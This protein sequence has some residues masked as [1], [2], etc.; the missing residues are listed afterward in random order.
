MTQKKP[1]NSESL[2]EKEEQ[3]N[4]FG[5]LIKINMPKSSAHKLIKELLESILE[6]KNGSPPIAFNRFSDW[7]DRISVEIFLASASRI[8]S[9]KALYLFWPYR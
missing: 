8:E 3:W 9:T 4:T 5:M 7:T 1:W 2:K 6:G